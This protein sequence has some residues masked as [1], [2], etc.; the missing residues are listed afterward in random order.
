MNQFKNY[1]KPALQPMRPY[2]QGED[3][4]EISVSGQ[5]TPEVGGMIAINPQNEKDQWYVAKEFFAANYVEDKPATLTFI[6]RLT[7]EQFELREKL[8]KL[9]AFFDTD[10]FKGLGEVDRELLKTQSD[11]MLAYLAIV[12]H[13]VNLYTADN[14]EG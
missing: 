12:D 6:G 9:V 3:L 4:S 11:A 1:R 7:V 13:R 5:D 2:V 14:S 10:V 8:D